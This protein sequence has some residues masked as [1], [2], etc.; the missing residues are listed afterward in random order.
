MSKKKATRNDV[1]DD[2]NNCN[3][4]NWSKKDFPFHNPRKLTTEEKQNIETLSN[5]E[6]VNLF[7]NVFGTEI[8][9]DQSNVLKQIK[10]KLNLLASYEN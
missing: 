5:T 1:V 7:N 6:L 10:N 3:K 9:T 2:C 4:I 8:D